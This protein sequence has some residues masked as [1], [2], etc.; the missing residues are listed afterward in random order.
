[1]QKSTLKKAVG[2]S[3]RVNPIRP[4]LL[5]CRQD[6]DKKI[7]F[8]LNLFIPVLFYIRKALKNERL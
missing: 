4:V 8:F 6:P 3:P 2:G 1:M 7:K 5:Y